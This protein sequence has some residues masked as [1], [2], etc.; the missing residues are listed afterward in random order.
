MLDG[1]DETQFN[2]LDRAASKIRSYALRTEV[3]EAIESARINANDTVYTEKAATPAQW[4]GLFIDSLET[5][6][7]YCKP[8]HHAKAW[9]IRNGVKW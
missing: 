2:A 9:F 4:A 7:C 8:S 5:V 1:R 6:L 3:Q